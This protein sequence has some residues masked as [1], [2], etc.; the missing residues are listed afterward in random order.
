M[1]DLLR[2]P[3]PDSTEADRVGDA[4]A[5][6][7]ML[8]RE[9]AATAEIAFS[10][11]CEAAR[12]VWW[13]KACAIGEGVACRVLTPAPTLRLLAWGDWLAAVAVCPVAGRP[14]ELGRNALSLDGVPGSGLFDVRVGYIAAAGD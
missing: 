13:Y 10:G 14:L 1:A 9:G 3:I 12:G 4:F 5:P 7:E 11:L 8:R 6:A 2:A